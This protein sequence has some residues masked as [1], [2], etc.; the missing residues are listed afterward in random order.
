MR[1]GARGEGGAARDGGGALHPLRRPVPGRRERG[2][3]VPIAASYGA[4]TVSA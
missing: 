2:E 4:C 3:V 1:G